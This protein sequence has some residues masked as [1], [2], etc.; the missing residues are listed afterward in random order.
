MSRASR[1]THPKTVIS[2]KFFQSLQSTSNCQIFFNSRSV[3]FQKIGNSLD[4]HSPPNIRFF[5]LII[6]ALEI[7]AQYYLY[8][9]MMERK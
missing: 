4:R 2:P 7:F 5:L 9:L 6:V 3:V 1:T 8:P